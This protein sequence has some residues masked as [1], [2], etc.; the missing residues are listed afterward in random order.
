MT[1]EEL[2]HDLVG[3]AALTGATLSKPS[4]NDPARARRVTIRPVLL[5]GELR[6][7]WTYYAT[8]QATR[9]N[10]SADET[11]RRLVH[12]LGGEFRQG[13][14]HAEDA[15][16]QVLGGAKV[17]RRPPTRPQ[18]PLE[19]DRR[20]RYVLDGRR[21]RAVPRRARR[22]DGRGEVH[23]RRYGKFRQVNRFL[24]LVGDVLP[25]LPDGLL[26][27]STSAPASRT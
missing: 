22:D 8:A 21:S 24:E 20:K 7:G 27:V 15:D 26:R 5:R 14:L 3:R 6:Y 23:A 2:V 17:L 25:A 4:R 9:E 12:V 11:E 10:L 18:T 19:H 13:L 1:V 16:Y